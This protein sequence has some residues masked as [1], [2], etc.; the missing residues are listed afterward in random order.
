[1]HRA[2]GP[3]L[4][5]SLQQAE[6]SAKL[7]GH[8]LSLLLTRRCGVELRSC[9]D[10]GVVFASIYHAQVEPAWVQVDIVHLAMVHPGVLATSSPT[11]HRQQVLLSPRK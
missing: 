5:R 11:M 7:M 3:L 1:M 10:V 9:S 6:G 8:M 4:C 2:V